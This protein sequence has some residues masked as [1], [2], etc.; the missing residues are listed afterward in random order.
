MTPSTWTRIK[1]WFGDLNPWVVDGG[2]ALFFVIIGLATTSGRGSMSH[3][4][5]Q[6]QDA[7]GVVLVLAAS[8][9]FVF[10]RRVP[11]TVLLFCTGAVVLNN[12]LGHN[13]GATPFFLWVAVITVAA[14]CA[15]WKV[16]VAAAWIFTALVV[17]VLAENSG[18]EA[19][20]FALNCALF[21]AMFMF[22]LNLKNRKERIEALE[23]RGQALEREK[24]EGARLAV[25]DERLHI[26]RELHDVVA[27]SMGVIA[28]QASV[29]EHVIDD[30]PAEAKRALEAISGVSRS[31]L[32]EIRR[33]LGVLR[34]TDDAAGGSPAYAPAPGLDDLDRLVARGR[35]RGRA[36][37][38]RLRRQP[39]RS[40]T[41]RRPHGVP[42][43]A[44]GPDQRA[45]TRGH[46]V[47]KGARAL[48]TR[49]A[50]TGDR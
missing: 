45:E 24:E 9:P 4:V 36:R 6:P 49:C 39:R 34:E 16:I 21:A 31:T 19:S 46:G 29:G 35:R 37:H 41:R 12:L 26:A 48:R 10:R 43:R 33:M 18:L 50:R 13:E 8:V 15:T 5:Y 14:T 7:F 11:L 28:V 40:T 22:G 23:E 2:I 44:G 38:R 1:D 3:D 25:A 32:A 30:N 17:L 42:H 27:H 20:G 47:G